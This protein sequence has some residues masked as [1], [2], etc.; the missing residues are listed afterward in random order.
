MT[1]KEFNEGGTPRPPWKITYIPEKTHTIPAQIFIKIE[2]PS[3]I[4]CSRSRDICYE[5]EGNLEALQILKGRLINAIE[6][7]KSAIDKG[8][9]FK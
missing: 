3:G 7:A 9:T 2:A 6:D 8:K 5:I 4:G 1:S